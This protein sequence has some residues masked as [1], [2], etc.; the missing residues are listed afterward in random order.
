MCVI[1]FKQEGDRR[2]M[3]ERIES[4]TLGRDFPESFERTQFR[5]HLT[6]GDIVV[7]PGSAI[8]AIESTTAGS[9]SSKPKKKPGMKTRKARTKA[10]LAKKH[11]SVAI[12]ASKAAAKARTRKSKERKRVRASEE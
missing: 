12:K 5:V 1:T 8:C 2:G 4:L 3:I 11:G 9:H 6:S 7:V 10:I